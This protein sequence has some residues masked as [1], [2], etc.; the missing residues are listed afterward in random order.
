MT[1]REYMA[2]KLKEFRKAKGMSTIEVGEAIGRSDK[3]VSAWE[4]GRGQP[5]ADMLVTLCQ[6]YSVNISDFY[7]VEDEKPTLTLS[8]DES[9]LVETYRLLDE[10]GKHAVI[11]LAE[12]LAG[13]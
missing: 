11:T 10:P 6:L 3:T 5:D 7:Q 9:H 12:G 1:T 13:E 2:A 4:V 8:Q